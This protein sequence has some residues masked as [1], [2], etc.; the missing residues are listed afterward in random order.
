MMILGMAVYN[1]FYGGIIMVTRKTNVK[2]SAKRILYKVIAVYNARFGNAAGA[3]SAYATVKK[4]PKAIVT[5]V[6][7]YSN[8]YGFVAKFVFVTPSAS[9]KNQ[10]VSGAKKSGAKVKVSTVSV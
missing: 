10:A 2:K 5:P 7:K 8:G 1:M 3:K 4:N 6:K 9:V